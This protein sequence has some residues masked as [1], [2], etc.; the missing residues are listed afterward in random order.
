MKIIETKECGFRYPDRSDW[1]FK[2]LNFSAFKGEI[3]Q[4]VGR[5]G[6][7]KTTFLKVLAAQLEPSEG[8]V[9]AHGGSKAVYMDQNSSDMVA[10]DLTIAEQIKMVTPVGLDASIQPIDLITLLKKFDI[11]L[12]KEPH[13]FVGQ[14]SGGQ[15]QIVSLISM[16]VSDANIICL[17]EFFSALDDN[18]YNIAC[19]L[20]DLYCSEKYKTIVFSSHMKASIKIDK[21]FGL[22]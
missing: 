6:T 10:H 21:E 3:I 16:L 4:V 17:D 1:V 7:G 19:E 12:E 20:I 2:N 9:L 13:K 5:N 14:L 22:G 18:S 11:G 15:K 8:E